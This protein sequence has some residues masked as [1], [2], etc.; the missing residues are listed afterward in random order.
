MRRNS[1]HGQRTKAA[2]VARRENPVGTDHDQRK[3]AFYP[4]Q[5]VGDGF[6]Q[7]VFFRERDQVHDHFSIAVGLKNRTLAVQPL[8]DILRIHQIAIVRQRHHAFVRLHHDGLGV[9]QRGIAR[10]RITRVANGQRAAQLGQNAFLK[11]IGDQAHGFVHV[12]SHAVG[13]DNARRLLAA[14]LQS[15]QA[16]VGELLGL[17]MGI[18]GH[19]PAFVA[20]FIGS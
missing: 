7:G 17:R 3:R 16:E 5:R 20:K 19:H 12:Q 8:P 6:R 1:A 9:E 13:G 11:N 4:A 15:V 10:R 2:R 14:M 18:D